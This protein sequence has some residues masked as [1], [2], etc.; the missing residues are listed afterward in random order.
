MNGNGI[1]A[2]VADLIGQ[3]KSLG[4]EPTKHTPEQAYNWLRNNAREKTP[5]RLWFREQEM[6]PTPRGSEA[7]RREWRDA[8]RALR[9]ATVTG[10]V[11]T[12]EQKRV[13]Q[14]ISSLT[15]AA[16]PQVAPGANTCA[17]CGRDLGAMPKGSRVTHGR[18]HVR[19]GEA[20]ESKNADGET[21][22]VAIGKGK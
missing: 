13:I 20:R 22:F 10:V 5:A 19:A 2:V 7:F 8:C 1:K 15:S 14:T 17:V 4:A 11:F 9:A 6:R 21:V 12:A 3:M 18:K 16:A